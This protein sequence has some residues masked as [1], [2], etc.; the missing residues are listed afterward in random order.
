MEGGRVRLNSQFSF[1]PLRCKAAVFIQVCAQYRQKTGFLFAPLAA[2]GNKNRL[3]TEGKNQTLGWGQ[4]GRETRVTI[5]KNSKS[6]FKLRKIKRKSHDIYIY[7]VG[8][9]QKYAMMPRQRKSSNPI[10]KMWWDIKFGWMEMKNREEICF[11]LKIGD[12]IF[13]LTSFL[14]LKKC[15][16]SFVSPQ[17]N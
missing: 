9:V 13:T 5:K 7:R 12:K 3:P 8:D 17:Q 6:N 4:G 2:V 14:F 1:L 16:I 11:V 15:K 10:S